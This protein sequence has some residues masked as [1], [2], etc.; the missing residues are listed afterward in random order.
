MKYIS[1]LIISVFLVSCGTTVNYDYDSQTNF[2]QYKTYNYFPD[3]DSGLSELDDKRIIKI[4][5]SL[6]QNRGFIKSETPQFLINFFAK[7]G[8]IHSKNTIGIGL[9]SGGRN[10]GVGISGGIP[11]GGKVIDQQ[12]TLDFVD[13]LKDDLFWQAISDGELKEKAT[14][15]Q[16]ETYYTKL[17]TKIL[18][19]F[20]PKK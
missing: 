2:S 11:I 1:V 4:T 10:V 18:K 7:E 13:S 16:K 8:N 19:G 17:L 12:L 14:P 3:I 20:P 6:L 5:D 9:G 15:I